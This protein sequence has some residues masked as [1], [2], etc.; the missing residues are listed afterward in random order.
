VKPISLAT[1]LL[2]TALSLP[3]E[4]VDNVLAQMVPDASVTLVGMRMDQLK[5]TPLFQKLLA[6][7]SLPQ[8]DEFAK[9]SG[10][11]PRRDVRDLLLAGNGQRSVL[12]ARGTFRL[13]LPPTAKK[14][15]YHGYVIISN[16]DPH[17]PVGA[18]FCILDASLA[19][20]GP[21]P[22][23]ETALDQYKSRNR[24]NAAALLARARAIPE[25]YQFWAVTAGAA[26]IISDNMPR[27]PGNGP[28]FARIFRSLQNVT[29]EAD[30]R[31]GL[32]AIAEGYCASAQDAKTL[33]D[34]ARGM[35]GMGR[36]NTPE[37]QPDLL[38]L[39]DGI[40]V[41]QQDKKILLTADIGQ[42]LIDQL[43]KL[44]QSTHR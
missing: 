36:L 12:L 25:T 33:S 4:R 14:F 30:L 16:A 1:A 15:N 2:L 41:E 42:D 34:A 38:R 29:F 9:E 3:A 6:Q 44:M 32:K 5:T 27:G 17:Q 37:N 21:L 19:A 7:Q 24:N 35:V 20:A 13:T 18:G 26:N 31:T 11:D 39:W 8:L 40:K 43:L 22:V 28:D 23:L 10:F